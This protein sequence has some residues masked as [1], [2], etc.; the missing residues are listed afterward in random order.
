MPREL[1]KGSYN[2]HPT[3]VFCSVPAIVTPNFVVVLGVRI[4]FED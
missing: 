3:A 1:R 2:D 4:A